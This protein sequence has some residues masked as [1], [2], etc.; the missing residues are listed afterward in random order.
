[1]CGFIGFHHS[2]Q[3]GSDEKRLI[4]ESLTR[5]E[6]RGPDSSG[7]F[8]SPETHTHLGHARLS[9]I[10]LTSHGAQPM[11]GKRDTH[12]VF[13]GEIYNYAGV[14]GGVESY[15]F[16]G[17]S[18]T[19]VLLAS[20]E[21]HG[22]TKTLQN[23]RGQFAFAWVSS[24]GEEVTLVRDRFGEKPLYYYV[25]ERYL[26]YA[27]ELSAVVMVMRALGIGV[28][29]NPI[30]ARGF[31]LLGYIA[32]SESLVTGVKRLLPGH[33]AIFGRKTGIWKLYS[34]S[35]WS[36]AWEGD[37]DKRQV[38]KKELLDTLDLAVGEQLVSDVPIG[39]F[40]SGGVDSSIIT[41][42]AKKHHPGPLHTF[43]IGFADQ[44]LNES[45]FASVVSL[46]LDT[47]HHEILMT[48][49]DALMAFEFLDKS[50]SEPLG[51]PSQLP[52]TF[53]AI[54]A[55]KQVTVALSGDGADELFF[56]YGRYERYLQ[57]TAGKS[58]MLL[59]AA[60]LI[61]MSSQISARLL[62]S[63]RALELARKAERISYI[64]K[65][66]S[67]RK[68]LYLGLVG[69]L[70]LSLLN[71]NSAVEPAMPIIFDEIE[72]GLSIDKLRMIDLAT[73]LTDDILVKVDRAT[74]AASL[75]SRAPFLDPR[76]SNLARSLSQENLFG[77]HEL[78]HLLKD[79][80]RD[81]VPHEIVDRPKMGFGPPIDRWMRT[82]FC[83][84]ADV[85]LSDEQFW[86]EIG[87]S[88]NRIA[89]IWRDHR[90]GVSNQGTLLWNLCRLR[91]T[92]KTLFSI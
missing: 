17:S 57:L 14:R 69:F 45:A 4:R 3:C 73:Y 5:I 78:K 80:A 55:R 74:M 52:T 12:L 59:A 29:I 63:S 51:D 75:E 72:S 67:S 35:P 16:V 26:I 1:M 49:D 87:C 11:T 41:A 50:F 56:G 91:H 28:E 25:D 61:A 64:A 37:L 71:E 13:N 54:S 38:T 20:L 7:E 36:P 84:W 79:I 27:S 66:L 22:L 60:P 85:Q 58:R 42:L 10:D 88:P 46:H 48:D 82:I 40:L 39:T 6:H 65:N 32:G 30:S 83:E 31:V 76:V 77:D 68:R 33:S 92:S 24:S 70:H 81:L 44:N 8:H 89:E 34:N 15:G 90:S 18:D 53:L 47:I 43:S 86:L 9:I 62:A 21:V 2:D 19:E 23:I